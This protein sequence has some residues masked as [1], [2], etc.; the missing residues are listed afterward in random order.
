MAS[1][2]HLHQSLRR[3]RDR[4]QRLPPRRAGGRQRRRRRA[5]RALRRGR[6]AGSPACSSTAAAMAVFCAPTIN[7][8]GRFRPNAMAPNAVTWGRDNRG[9]MLRVLGRAGDAGDADREPHRRAAAP[10]R[11]STSPRRSTPGSTASSAAS[12]APPATA[13]PY[14]QA[15]AD[16][17][18]GCRPA[19]ARRSMRSPPTSGLVARLRRAGRRLA[20]AGQALRARRATT[21]PRTRTPGRR[22]NTSAAS[23]P[24]R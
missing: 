18:A 11:T 7:A 3:P 13:A 20:D 16:A 22:A 21:R 12:T 1:G 19:S 2:W 8:Y 14:A 24:A 6:V 15:G 10:I 4:R 17:A 9:A 23:R 5:A